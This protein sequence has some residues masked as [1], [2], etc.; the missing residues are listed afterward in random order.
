MPARLGITL[1]MIPM[2]PPVAPQA[3]RLAKELC[4][5]GYDEIWMAETST[6]E[7]FAL[8]GALSQAVPGVRIGTGIVPLQTRS[9]MVHAMG[10]LTLHELTGGKFVLGLGISSENIVGDWAG[11]PFD[12]P[13]TRMR[14]AIAVLRMALAG[15]KVTF[16]GE[17]V[18]AKNLRLSGK[19]E[20]LAIY[21]AALNKR[22]LR[23]TGALADGLVLNMVPEDALAQVLA[24]VRQGALDA[25]RDPD[26]I[27]V[28]ARLH[29]N[30]APSLEAGRQLVRL[31]FGPYAA[32]SGY[33]RFFRGI[34]YSEAGDVAQAFAKGDR[35]GVAAAMSDR[36]CDAIAVTG[37]EA[38]V[39]RRIRSY[40]ERGV[41]VCV[42]N[43]IASDAASQRRVYDTLADVLKGIVLSRPALSRCT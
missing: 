20:G 34:G 36:L 23:L 32:A 5:R 27:E 7:S 9:A 37:D 15:E 28:V 13:L 6:A 19:A 14:E 1:P 29:V 42:L 11:Q 33:N 31:A 24:E 40:A 25:G 17:T 4:A 18:Q 35:S 3:V 39:R 10:A 8:A 43:P 30:I 38:H 22:M 41:D 21:I 26:K 12:R 2:T 16:T